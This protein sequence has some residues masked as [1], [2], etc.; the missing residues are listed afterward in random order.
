MLSLGRTET[1]FGESGDLADPELAWRLRSVCKGSRFSW[2]QDVF[3]PSLLCAQSRTVSGGKS[4]VTELDGTAAGRR[5]E[6]TEGADLGQP[7]P[8]QHRLFLAADR[9][10]PEAGRGLHTAS[11]AAFEAGEAQ[12][13]AWSVPGTPTRDEPVSGSAGRS[14]RAELAPSAERPLC[15]GMWRKVDT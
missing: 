9:A 3:R 4:P 15:A 5:T 10:G 11:A 13:S 1:V 7:V 8:G 14:S 2:P 12:S 6:W